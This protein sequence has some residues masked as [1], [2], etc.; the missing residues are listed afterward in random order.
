MPGSVPNRFFSDSVAP[1]QW[2]VFSLGSEITTSA[3][4]IVC[5]R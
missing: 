2:C 5:D 3:V 1:A 4:A